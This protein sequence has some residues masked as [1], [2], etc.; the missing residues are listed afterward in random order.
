MLSEFFK[1]FF[2]GF[3]GVTEFKTVLHIPRIALDSSWSIAYILQVPR[4]PIYGYIICAT[5][6]F[7]API[8]LHSFILEA[9]SSFTTYRN[10]E[11][12]EL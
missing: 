4:K 5:A 1:L 3:G 12:G 8:Y 7:Y 10:A 6:F 11:W 2:G 9:L